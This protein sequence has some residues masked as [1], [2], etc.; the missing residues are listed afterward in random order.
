MAGPTGCRWWE[1]GGGEGDDAPRMWF[2]HFFFPFIRN[3]VFK[4]RW[5]GRRINSDVCEGFLFLQ[6]K[7]SLETEEC[8]WFEIGR[9]GCML[10]VVKLYGD[11]GIVSDHAW[12][13][14]YL[15]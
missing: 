3:V 8:G 13:G 9:T 7:T 6:Q 5:W 10:F 4:L 2:F 14:G 15:S 12:A 11:H 1:I